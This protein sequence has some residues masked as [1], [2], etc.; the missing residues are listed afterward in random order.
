MTSAIGLAG[1]DA[2][3][4]DASGL[5]YAGAWSSGRLLTVNPVTGVA[6]TDIPVTAG[7][8]NN[9]VADLAIDPTTGEVWASRGGSQEGRIVR[10]NPQ[11]G[12]VT[13]ILDL[14]GLVSPE[15]TAIA[16]DV[17][18]QMYVSVGGDQLARVDKETGA[19]TLIGTGF[20]GVK[21]SGLGFEP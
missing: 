19:Y 21:M 17:D 16:F 8:G 13:R 5:L 2:I 3:A 1:S 10:I 4:H 14:A 11:T 20:G 15:I 18:G 9:H 12:V 7:G 6:L